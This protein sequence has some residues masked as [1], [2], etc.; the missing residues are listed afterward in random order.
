MSV[1]IYLAEIYFVDTFLS[2]EHK[3]P[4]K[5]CYPYKL[6][7]K[8]NDLLFDIEIWHNLRFQIVIIDLPS[9]ATSCCI[10][11]TTAVIIAN[12]K[13]NI[14]MLLLKLSTPFNYL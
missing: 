7:I 5:S 6:I 2:I 14:V 11:K 4:C 8:V 10:R 3:D 12:L 13:E 1:G 9:A